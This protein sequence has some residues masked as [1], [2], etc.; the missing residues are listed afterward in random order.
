MTLHYITA[1]ESHG[2]GLTA[3]LEG[4]PAGLPIRTEEIDHDL[5]RRQLGY[6]RGGRMKIERDRVEIRGGVRK[7]ETLGSPVALFIENKDWTNWKEVMSETPGPYDLSKRVTRPR[8]G[9][10]DLPGGIKYGHRDL[11]NIL[12]RSS[13]RETAA[14]VAVGAV[15]RKLLSEFGMIV[16]SHVVSIGGVEADREEKV[17]QKKLLNRIEKSDLRC[18]DPAAAE[19]MRKRID[20]AVREGD[21]L[22]GIFEVRVTN[23][24]IGLGSH[25]HYERK[26]NARLAAAVMSIQAVKG[27]E[28]GIGFAAAR[29]PGSEVHDEIYYSRAKGF[30]HRTNR[31]GGIEGGMSNGE[32]IVLRAVMKPIPTLMRPLR[33]V[34]IEN[35]RSFKAGVE[36]SDVCA[37]PAAGVIA[38]A[39]VSFEIARAMMEKF[40]GDSL[41]EMQRN[42]RHYLE[43]VGRY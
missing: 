21:S 5:A 17:F 16:F 42:F 12:E 13:A 9:H 2:K 31:A 11:R 30:Y 8:P 37:V 7:G 33:S 22:G 15:A 39:A 40:G 19:R 26:L 10:A 28:I 43:A 35:K 20:E 18:A 6:G 1:G 32:E 24:P 38:E 27:V 3:I 25:V 4:M 23:V 29:R 14:R 36:R 34:D 41:S